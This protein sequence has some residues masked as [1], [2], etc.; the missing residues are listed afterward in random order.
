MYEQELKK[1]FEP[2]REYKTKYFRC[3]YSGYRYKR[4]T[5][6]YDFIIKAS[7]KREAKKILKEYTAY[8]LNMFNVSQENVKIIIEA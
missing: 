8:P 2:P 7:D 1:I 3:T 5:V 4:N 6:A